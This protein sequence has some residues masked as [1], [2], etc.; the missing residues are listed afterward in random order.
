MPNDPDRSGHQ[1]DAGDRWW[2]KIY[3]ES[4]RNK[5]IANP[6]DE[7]A[8][9]AAV[10]KD[11]WNDYVVRAEGARIRIWINGVAGS[12]Y[13]EADPKIPLEGRIGLQVHG[14]GKALVQFKDMTIEELPATPKH[15]GA[16]EPK[17]EEKS[18]QPGAAKF[19]LKDLTGFDGRCDSFAFTP[20]AGR[21]APVK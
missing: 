19:T 7:K 21:V 18:A 6:A 12:D 11:D 1:S 17:K 4:R 3:D 13:I 10:K 16:P 9:T 20:A 8:L 5:V 14:G 15:E 2:G